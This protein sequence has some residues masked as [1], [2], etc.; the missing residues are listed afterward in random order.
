MNW[1]SDKIQLIASVGWLVFTISFA[2]WWFTLSFRH[3]SLLI[4]LQPTEVE[5]WYRQQRMILWEG[6]A[7]LVLLALGGA[8][9]IFLIQRE[10]QRI[11]QIREFFA[12]FT[13][14]IKTSLA[15]LRLQA[16]TIQDDVGATGSPVVDRLIGDTVR[17][18]LQLENSLF[19]ASQ[20]DLKLFLEGLDLPVLIRRVAEQWPGLTVKIEGQ[21]RVRADERAVR[22]ILS[23]LFQNALIHGQAKSLDVK[24]ETESGVVV[25]HL[26]DNGKGFRGDVTGLGRVFHRPTATSGSGLGLYISKALMERMGGRVA[27]QSDS[28]GFQT[29]L[30][31]TS[32]GGSP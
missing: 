13:H 3:I 10:R 9:L 20:A 7:W 1:R 2:I 8:A 5:H 6:S 14:E 28:S 26:T 15:S 11:R 23:N 31:F 12:S 21:G 29:H 27:W 25:V 32:A 22:T 30:H 18:Q 19:F 17:L 24:I 4:Q 16:E